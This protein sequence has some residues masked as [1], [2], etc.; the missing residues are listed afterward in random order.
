MTFRKW[1]VRG[2]LLM[3]MLLL[4]GA[5]YVYGQYTNPEAVAQMVLAEL[6]QHFPEAD[7]QLGHAEWRLFGGI[8][9]HDLKVTPKEHPGK[10]PAAVLRQTTLKIDKSQAAQGKFELQRVQLE[11]P[12]LNLE[13]DE[14]G[15]W[16]VLSL[17]TAKPKA[18]GTIPFVVLSQGTIRFHDRRL[19]F[20]VLELTGVEAKLIPQPQGNLTGD[21]Q[22]HS[23]L[24][25]L[26]QFRFSHDPDKDT[27]ELSFS[28]P[29]V[30][31]QPKLEDLIV[32]LIPIWKEQQIRVRGMLS[33]DTKLTWYPH[34]D[35]PIIESKVHLQ[36]GELRHPRLPVPLKGIK[37]DLEYRPE[38]LIIH[39]FAAKA[40]KGTIGGNGR[41]ALA[42]DIRLIDQ[43]QAALHIDFNNIHVHKG[44]FPSLPPMLR[45]FCEE[46]QT[47]G[48]LNGSIDV[49]YAQHKLGLAY[50]LKPHQASFEA[51]VFPYPANNIS[52]VLQYREDGEEPV[53]QVDLHGQF[54][55][56]PFHIQGHLN[57]HG[58]RPDV[59]LKPGLDLQIHAEGMPLDAALYRALEP[60]PETHRV[61]MQFHAGGRLDCDIRIRRESGKTQDDIP[62]VQRWVSASLYDVQFR[63]DPFPCPVEKASGK[64]DIYP[65]KT[66]RISQFRGE[67]RGSQITGQAWMV[68]TGAGDVLHIDLIA[69]KLGFTSEL[70][71]AMPP[72]V[73]T[74]WKHF[75]PVGQIDC[76]VS[77]DKLEKGKPLVEVAVTSRGATIT[78]A[79]FP[80]AINNLQGKFHY[81]N[82]EVKV[83]S[84]TG[85][86]GKTSISVDGGH[87]TIRPGAGFLVQLEGI[88]FNQLNIDDELLAALP[89]GMR[90]GA[91][92]LKLNKPINVRANL[93]VDE[94]G[95]TRPPKLDWSGSI[96]LNDTHVHAGVGLENVTGVILMEQGSYDIGKLDCQ[97]QLYVRSMNIM[98]KQVVGPFHSKMIVTKDVLQLPECKL[99]IPGGGVI[100]L[101]HVM[102]G[103][104]GVR[105]HVN[106][107]ADFRVEEFLHQTRDLKG[108]VKAELRL[109]GEGASLQKLTGDGSILVEQGSNLVNLPLVID[110]FNQFSQ[111]LPKAT[112]FQTAKVD[113]VVQGDQL[114]ANQ[115]Q[116]LGD[117][118][119]V[120]GT[121]SA[122]LD[123]SNL[124]LTLCLVMGGGRTL[125]LMPAVLDTLQK[126]IA[127]GLMKVKV[128]GSVNK[129]DV[130][131]EPVP[132]LTEPVR[133]VFRTIS[134]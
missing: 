70:F 76:K 99:S 13:R 54:G 122:K 66:W 69:Q 36:N 10:E 108:R 113:F 63:F 24:L 98:G 77:F 91:A 117:A 29:S 84:L 12:L 110:I 129:L 114:K 96:E 89:P 3:L 68:G 45:K 5:Y 128:T 17:L 55:T 93:T 61:I 79:N 73:Q 118:Y 72:E 52:G 18:S 47:L 60:Y 22:G 4:G 8:L 94:P 74:V 86:H 25:G 21:G 131:V 33:L 90:E 109:N 81:A 32:G 67:H 46:M 124:D 35:I 40:E 130:S 78:S 65:D 85:D 119:R 101:I 95:E 104:G 7:I 97:G 83:S 133:D 92:S 44:V 107:S 102:F 43:H 105:Y 34:Q 20:P 112:N 80:Y 116:L 103:G 2:F 100:G 53:L 56:R 51:D 127:K 62:P 88:S 58:L 50:T 48:Q 111:M 15:R 115:L 41:V 82:Q 30:E 27:T 11:Q 1:L 19:K 14:A 132:F 126:T 59:Q 38:A 125:P 64:L 134:R 75:K 37:A 31:F 121:G 42:S 71:S 120:E 28:I 26:I 106:A 39:S 6:K 123:G 57:G 49:T 9:L 87:V 23:A 16:N